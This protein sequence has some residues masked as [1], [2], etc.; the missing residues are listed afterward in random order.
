MKEGGLMSWIENNEWLKPDK[1]HRIRWDAMRRFL[2]HYRPY[3]ARLAVAGVLALV[4]SST[5]FLI[6][7]IFRSLQR[8]LT[9]HDV[10]H[11]TW[12]ILAFL[13]VTLLEICV[14]AGIR[15]LQSL[16]SI[17]LN[18]DLLLRYYGKI[19]NLAVEDFI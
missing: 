18:R 1:D 3:R 12:M 16:V 19:L 13:G 9:G 2:E 6:P 8:A 10:H 17:Q 15:L 5:V 14:S 7:W 11:I 4:A